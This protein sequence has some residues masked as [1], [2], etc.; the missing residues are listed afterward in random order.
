VGE[1]EMRQYTSCPWCDATDKAD[2]RSRFG[3]VSC[4]HEFHSEPKLAFVTTD[5]SATLVNALAEIERMKGRESMAGKQLCSMADEIERKD[6]ALRVAERLLGWAYGKLAYRSF[7]EMDDCLAM[8][9]IKL[10][11]MEKHCE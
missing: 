5:N 3:C 9:E 2:R 11:L 4:Q 10:I 7:S 1:D 8:D 6:A